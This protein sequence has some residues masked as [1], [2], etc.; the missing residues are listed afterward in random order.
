MLGG[1]LGA[2][3]RYGMYL[4]MP[5]KDT[6]VHFPWATLSVNLIGCFLIG[7]LW[8]LVFKHQAWHAFLIVGLL[9]G[10]TTFSSFGL[11]SIKLIQQEAFTSFTLYVLTSNIVGLL[12]VVAGVKLAEVTNL[13]N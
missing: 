9:G 12:F 11:D 7:L 1:G 4:L 6:D 3:M 10:F 2:G 13:F 5:V 8:P